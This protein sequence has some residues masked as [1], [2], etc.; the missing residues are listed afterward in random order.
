VIIE[1]PMEL[2]T[3]PK[4]NFPHPT[5]QERTALLLD[6]RDDI[7]EGECGRKSAAKRGQEP[8]QARSTCRDICNIP[9]KPAPTLFQSTTVSAAVAKSY[10]LTDW[11]VEINKVWN[12][13]ASKYIGPG[14]GGERGQ[15]RTATA[16]WPMS[17]LWKSGECRS[18]RAQPTG[19]R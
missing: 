10:T 17:Q 1:P 11:I 18:P 13:G 4:L 14:Q 16:L 9:L 8:T 12:R 2:T 5:T 15:D 3:E 7:Q 6:Q 19:S